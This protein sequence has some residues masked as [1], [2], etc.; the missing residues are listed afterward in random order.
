M[1][2]FCLG[3]NAMRAAFRTRGTRYALVTGQ[4][5]AACT[6]RRSMGWIQIAGEAIA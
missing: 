2:G 1:A 6:S 3:M 4:N 5:S